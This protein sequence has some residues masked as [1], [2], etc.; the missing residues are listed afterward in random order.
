MR[1]GLNIGYSGAQVALPMD[2]IQEADHLGYHAVWDGGSLRLGL[3][4]ARWP[5]SAL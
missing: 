4:Y 3:Y 2:L 5:G 1:L